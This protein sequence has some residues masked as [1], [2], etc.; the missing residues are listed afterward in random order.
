VSAVLA[1]PAPCAAEL[2]GELVR[3]SFDGGGAAEFHR[4]ALRDACRCPACRH[5]VSGQRLF[6]TTDVL[7]AARIVAIGLEEETLMLEWADGHRSSFEAAWLAAEA[8]AASS[9][10]RPPRAITLWGAELAGELP[11]AVYRDLL[12]DPDALERW[13][14][15][16]AEFGF[17]L[18]TGAP[19]EEGVVA[20]VAELFGPVRETNYGRVFDVT[21]RAEA[22]NLADTA[23]ALSLHTDNPYREPAPSLQ[24]LHCLASSASG[25]ETVLAD[26]FRAV[27]R[28]ALRAPRKL[29]LLSSQPIRFSYRDESAELSTDVPVVVLDGDGLPVALHVNNRA[30]DVPV[31]TPGAVAEWYEAY[32]ALLSL[33]ERPEA[34]VVL[35]LEPGQLIAFDNLRVLHGRRGFS[36]EG[37]RRLQGCYADR[38]ALLSRLAVLGRRPG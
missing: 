2:V 16:I 8:Q 14:A 5:P 33:L 30:K 37:V 12:A 29:A 19:V 35:R 18:V 11:S 26:G 20:S 38:D 24:L 1:R 22:R 3:V 15:A 10:R 36:G 4:L 17:A 34:E 28:L 23:R 7:P 32:F 27:A 9:G 21:V 13:L 6:E 31:G 25:G